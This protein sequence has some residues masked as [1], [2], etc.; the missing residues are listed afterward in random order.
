[1]E[2]VKFLVDELG[3]RTAKVNALVATHI[4]IDSAEAFLAYL[5]PESENGFQN[6]EF[7]YK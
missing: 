7:I 3:F 5:T 6:H 4:D 1:M 2:F